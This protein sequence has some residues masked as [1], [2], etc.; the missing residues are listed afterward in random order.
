VGAHLRLHYRSCEIVVI[1]KSWCD[2]YVY[3]CIGEVR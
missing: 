1:D 3:E 2:K